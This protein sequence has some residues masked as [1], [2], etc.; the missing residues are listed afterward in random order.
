MTY[1]L[2]LNQQN[3]ITVMLVQALWGAISPNFRR[4]AISVAAPVWRFD[5]VL[6]NDNDVDRDEIEDVVGEFDA[7]A[8]GLFSGVETYQVDITVSS[9][10]LDILDYSLW[11]L[12]YL[13]RELL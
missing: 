1:Q 9:K 6:E 10:P 5:F 12:V 4:V 13:R 2:D 3:T 8:W 11:R 7:L